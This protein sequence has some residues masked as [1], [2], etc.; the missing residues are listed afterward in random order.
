MLSTLRRKV[1]VFKHKSCQRAVS[2]NAWRKSFGAF[3]SQ[4]APG[5]VEARKGAR[6]AS[7]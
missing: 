3:W 4:I 7:L 6:N 5:Q 1:V 2:R